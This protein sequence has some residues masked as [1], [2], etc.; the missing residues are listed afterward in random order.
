MELLFH[1]CHRRRGAACTWLL[2]RRS[3]GARQLRE[4][5]RLAQNRFLLLTVSVT[6]GGGRD[7]ALPLLSLEDANGKLHTESENGAS[8]ENWFGLLRNI[9]PAQTQQGR[10]LFDVPLGSY[11]LRLTDG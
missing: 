11:K 4:L 10:M 1:R 5:I 7:V 9:S 6:N 8:V 2:P 3:V